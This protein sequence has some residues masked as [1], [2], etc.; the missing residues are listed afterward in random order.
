MSIDNGRSPAVKVMDEAVD[1]AIEG[2]S[3]RYTHL[4][5]GDEASALDLGFAP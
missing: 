1:L 4:L 2:R 3:T 5:P